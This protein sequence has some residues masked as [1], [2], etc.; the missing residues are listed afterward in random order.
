MNNKILGIIFFSFVWITF[1]P[2]AFAQVNDSC[3]SHTVRP[4]VSPILK[5]SFSIHDGDVFED[6]GA[7]AKDWMGRDITTSIKSTG[8]VNT[9]TTGEYKIIYTVTDCAGLSAT[10]TRIV[11]VKVQTCDDPKASNYKGE[12]VCTH[13]I[14]LDTASNIRRIFKSPEGDLISKMI[15]ATGLV[16]SGITS[17]SALAFATP[18]TSAEIFLLP[19]RLWS[20]ILIALGLKK[21][22][23]EWGTIYDSVTKRPL[24]PVFLELVDSE[25]RVV[26]TAF[27]DLDGRYGFLAKPGH[28]MIRPKKTNYVFPSLLLG[29][30]TRDEVYLDLYFG[31][32]FEIKKE[33][34]VIA[35]NV[36]MDSEKFD[37]NEFE[38]KKEHQNVFYS[39]R[40]QIYT[41]IS[42]MLFGFGL[43]ISILAFAVVMNLYNSIILGV[44]LLMLVL[45]EVGVTLSKLGIVIDKNSRK[46]LPYCIVR[47]YSASLN[48][49]VI[50]KVANENGQFYM[51]I[52]N[53]TYFLVIEKKNN[54]SYERVFTGNPFRVD[55]GIIK[56]IWEV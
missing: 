28:Y 29:H 39:K 42:D 22:T 36:P 9:S 13:S 18:F 35:K 21:R 40:L 20:L 3:P 5:D 8:L 15:A 48:N 45:R 55:K 51:L 49:E 43:L 53:G 11:N 23:R 54:D 52:P 32:Y 44:Y 14:A 41:K 34:E 46:P 12:G 37:W 27:T 19:I 30:V 50:H 56:G 25:G 33:G 24:D 2:S 17:I 47:A 16:V 6:P 26:T 7:T 1:S 31:N 4:I 38:K 10:A